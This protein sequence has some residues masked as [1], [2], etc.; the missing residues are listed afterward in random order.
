MGVLLA[1][2]LLA[3]GGRVW[4]RWLGRFLVTADTPRPVDALV[5]LGGGG[6]HRIEA[7]ARLA[8]AGL[9]PWLVV[10][11]TRITWRW[12]KR[13]CGWACRLN[14]SCPRPGW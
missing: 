10:T 4:L 1:V 8:L 7:G 14:A 6:R 3:L 12:R 5:V 2:V 9:A 13:R 11:N